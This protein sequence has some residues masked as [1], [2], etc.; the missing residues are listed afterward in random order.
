[1]MG[2]KYGLD[3]E[4]LM[5]Q[6][7]ILPVQCHPYESYQKL[8]AKA[9]KDMSPRDPDDARILALARALNLPIWSNDKD[10]EGY[11]ISWW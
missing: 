8:F 1:M 11:T 10:L 3:R 5:L 9:V 2:E 7:K 6:L 4:A